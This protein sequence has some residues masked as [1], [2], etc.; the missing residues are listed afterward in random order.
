MQRKIN[1][2]SQRVILTIFFHLNQ[3]LITYRVLGNQIFIHSFYFALMRKTKKWFKL[4]LVLNS[5]DR[6]TKSIVPR[7]LFNDSKRMNF[8]TSTFF[9]FINKTSKII[10]FLIEK[11]IY[12]KETNLFC[13][14]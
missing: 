3:L 4:K 7:L 8:L 9:F 5:R 11:S 12:S 10:Y 13:L 6:N 1:R 14:H 2:I